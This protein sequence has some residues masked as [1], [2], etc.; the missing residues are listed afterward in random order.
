MLFADKEV[1][2]PSPLSPL[3]TATNEFLC[4]DLLPNKNGKTSKIGIKVNVTDTIKTLHVVQAFGNGSA[5][6]YLA[7]PDSELG[8]EYYVATYCKNSGICHFAVTPVQS[9]TDICLYF[10]NSTI[11]IEPGLCSNSQ[12]NHNFKGY[13]SR[14]ECTLQEHD[15]I[16]FKSNSDLTGTKI[17]A[18]KKIAVFSGSLVTSYMSRGESNLLIEQLPPTSHWGKEFVIVPSSN[19]A[20]DIVKIVTQAD[21]TEIYISGFSPFIIPERGQSF[22]KRIDKGWNCVIKA[23]Y[24]VLVMQIF[25]LTT[26]IVN[27][28]SILNTTNASLPSM[29]LVPAVTQWTNTSSNESSPPDCKTEYATKTFTTGTNE[30]INGTHYSILGTDPNEAAS[31]YRI[32]TVCNNGSSFL[33]DADWSKRTQ[34]RLLVKRVHH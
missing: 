32:Y 9:N 13:S 26:L 4:E 18:N 15:V 21:N 11:S 12:Q 17:S 8:Y 2:K 10:N 25:G 27:G 22:E 1:Y 5:E 19:E 20:G 3:C 29:T 28:S 14:I 30:A 16:Y 33:Y 6:G 31:A 24:P 34:V 7:I 23:S